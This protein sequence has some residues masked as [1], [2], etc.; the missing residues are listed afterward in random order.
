MEGKAY[1]RSILVFN[2]NLL[3]YSRRNLY[4]ASSGINHERVQT[5]AQRMQAVQDPVIP[6]IGSWIKQHPGTISLGQGVVHYGP[7]EQAREK[8]GEFWSNPSNHRYSPV[9][10]LS[11]LKERIRLKL[12]EENGIAAGP[13]LHIA[14]TAGA[15]MGFLNALFAITDPGDEVV[16]FAPYY[17][18]HEMAVA[19][20]GCNP[21]CVPLDRTY[22]IDLDRLAGSL[23]PRTRAVVT[24]SPN[25]PAGAVYPPDTL[26]EINRLCRERGVYHINDEAYEYFVYD[27][28]KHFSPGSLPEARSHTISIFSLSKSF[29]FAGWRIGYMAFPEHLALPIA[30]V[31]DTNIICPAVP[32]QFAALGALEAGAAYPKSYLD[33]F[34]DVR[35]MLIRSLSGHERVSVNTPQGAFYTMVDVDTRQRP[36]EVIRYLIETHRVAAMPGE[37]FGIEE[38]CTL[39]VAFGALKKETLAEGIGRLAEGL[40]ALSRE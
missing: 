32:S 15:N 40:R 12:L 17:F 24:V 19:M 6:L 34:E 28:L 10:G 39:R 13:D 23:T 25:N 31:Q 18:N 29:G 38:G 35:N 22:Q 37:A 36:L 5:M 11:A 21:V 1:L 16:L 30:K 7:P 33:D 27:G 20:L 8:L 9:S 2:V 26:V 4:P 3:V 14:V